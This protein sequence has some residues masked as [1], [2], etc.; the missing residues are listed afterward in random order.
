MWDL[1]EPWSG[2]HLVIDAVNPLDKNIQEIIAY[3]QATND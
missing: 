1:D 3:I 2:E